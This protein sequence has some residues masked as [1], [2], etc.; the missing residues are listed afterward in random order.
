MDR[1]GYVR[2][3]LS[4]FA[5]KVYARF[6]QMLPSIAHADS[7]LGSKHLC[8][9]IESTLVKPM[10]RTP[11]APDSLTKPICSNSTHLSLL[12]SSAYRAG[13]H[14]FT[15]RTRKPPSTFHEFYHRPLS[16]LS[17]STGPLAAALPLPQSQL[18][19]PCLQLL[20][21]LDRNEPKWSEHAMLVEPT[22]PNVTIVL[23]ANSVEAEAHSVATAM[24]QD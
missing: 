13:K 2:S 5:Y 8:Q 9:S 11:F 21:N 17:C 14:F 16:G 3:L 24:H 15:C 7:H 10:R 6:Q 1:G 20:Q 4:L 19:L 12:M 18:L 23:Y 22:V